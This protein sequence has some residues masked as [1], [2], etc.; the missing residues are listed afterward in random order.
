MRT[1][2]FSFLRRTKYRRLIEFFQS[3]D[4]WFSGF[5][6][7]L[8]TT[9]WIG[10]DDGGRN[11]GKTRSNSNL[12]KKQI[13]GLEAGAKSAQPPWIDFMKVALEDY[14]VESFEQ[15]LDIVSVRI[16]KTSGKLS[17]KTDRSSR[18]EYF[19]LGTAPTE[20]VTQDNS[21]EILDGSDN[22]TEQDIF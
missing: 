15:P 14:P 11:L 7:R 21:D 12:G 6:R 20:Y 3:K 4:A 10:F 22:T 8:V 16:D 19:K 9:S 13:F 1:Y 18:F 17:S 5:S 2:L